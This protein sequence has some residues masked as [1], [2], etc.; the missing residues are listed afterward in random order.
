MRCEHKTGDKL[1]V[2]YAGK[3]MAVIDRNTRKV[4]VA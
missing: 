3:T 1:Y 2:D 4:Q